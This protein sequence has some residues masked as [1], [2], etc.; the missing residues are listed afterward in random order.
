[1]L[2]KTFH[3]LVHYN[4]FTN[5]VDFWKMVENSKKKC[6]NNE[7]ILVK[8]RHKIFAFKW[9]MPD[10]KIFYSEKWKNKEYGWKKENSFAV[11]FKTIVKG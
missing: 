6:N 1:M 4:I 10:K 3:A 2:Y 11:Q 5:Y 7:K 9:V 8:R